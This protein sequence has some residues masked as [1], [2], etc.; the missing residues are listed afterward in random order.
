M[1]QT[2]NW[3]QVKYDVKLGTLGRQVLDVSKMFGQTLGV[4]SLHQNQVHINVFSRFSL[5]VQ[6]ASILQIFI[7]GAI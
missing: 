2:Q 5:Q 4:S 3:L 1:G 7:C 6:T